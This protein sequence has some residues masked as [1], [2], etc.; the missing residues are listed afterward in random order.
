MRTTHYPKEFWDY[1]LVEVCGVFNPPLN[2][3]ALDI[4]QQTLEC[5]ST[6]EVAQKLERSKNST[7]DLSK[8]LF[9][10]IWFFAVTNQS[11]FTYDK[12]VLQSKQ[13]SFAQR[14]ELYRSFLDYTWKKF[15]SLDGK[16]TCK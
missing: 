5:G 9:K 1:I 13:V 3:R 10:R 11:G 7:Y 4:L 12:H 16:P 14:R 8:R 15:N 2:Q 6:L